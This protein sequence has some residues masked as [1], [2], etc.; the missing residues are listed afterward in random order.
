[1]HNHQTPAYVQHKTLVSHLKIIKHTTIIINRLKYYQV[2]DKTIKIQHLN[3]S[4][5]D[6]G[7]PSTLACFKLIQ[8]I[9]NIKITLDSTNPT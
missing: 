2:K 5:H 8:S 1:M 7:H 3:L 4:L 9:K 6:H